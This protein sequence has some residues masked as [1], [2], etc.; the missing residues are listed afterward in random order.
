MDRRDQIRYCRC[1]TRLASDNTG[2]LCSACQHNPGVN[3]IAAPSVPPAFWM[4]DQMRDALATRHI[5][6]IIYAY[7]TNHFHGQVVSQS[8][9][10]GWASISQTQISRIESG[11][12]VHDLR[13]LAHW[14]RVLRIPHRLLWF[15][16]DGHAGSETPRGS[17]LFAEETQE[18]STT[19][20]RDFVALGGSAIAGQAFGMLERELDMIHIA[21]DRGTT[22]EERISYI[23]EVTTSLGVQAATTAPAVLI[24][25][26]LKTLTSIR[27][28]LGERQPTRQQ[29]RLVQ[30]SARLS[31]ILGQ[32]MF[33]LSHF[34]KA[35]DWY[36]TAEHAAHDARDGYLVDI[37]LAGQV[38]IPLYSDDPREV[39]ALL[40]PRLDGNSHRSPARAKLWGFKARAHA[41]LNEP[42]EFRHSIERAQECLARS[43]ADLIAPG[44]FSFRPADLAFAEATGSV[45]LGS[46]DNA[47]SAADRALSL[48]DDSEIVNPA[49][50]RLERA[51]A[52]AQTGE[53]PEA[54]RLARDTIINPRT[55]YG[56]AVT[57]YAVRF[58]KHIRGI[59]SP[60]TREWRK[61]HAEIS[62][63]KRSGAA[64][65]TPGARD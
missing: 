18:V 17:S 51:S 39:I 7:R 46:P 32:A 61:A 57:A 29:V 52:L 37:S 10:A 15:R 50:T 8:A 45:L 19:R 34:R 20:R 44:I 49:L 63:R 13:R 1:G 5:G 65:A 28:L 14:A 3:L 35:G 38:L 21:L 4:T 53:V 55:Y 2:L 11:P 62:R 12:P 64:T 25:P 42:R 56:P 26:A 16:L 60:E 58:E 43:P 9:V 41:T 47:I 6:K 40:S 27:I 59:Q 24:E 23:E 36:Q 54:C 48:Y 30:A 22:S 33:N 31:A